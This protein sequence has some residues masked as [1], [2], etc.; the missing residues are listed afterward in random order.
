ELPLKMTVVDG[1]AVAFNMPDP[2]SDGSVSVTTL[3]VRHSALATTLKM[4]FEAVWAQ[5]DTL[6]EALAK[7]EYQQPSRCVLRPSSTAARQIQRDGC[8]CLPTVR[9]VAGADRR[10]QDGRT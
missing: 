1:K 2:V 10:A 9:P 4:S 6:D 5:S 7:R 3:I 8:T